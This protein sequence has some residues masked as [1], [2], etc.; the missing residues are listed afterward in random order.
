MKVWMRG[1]AAPSIASQAASMSPGTQRASEAMVGVR[2][3]LAMAETASKSPGELAANPAS[4]MST[5]SRSSCRAIS[6]FSSS[7]RPIPADCSPSRSVVSKISTLSLVAMVFLPCAVGLFV[8]LTP[9]SV[10]ERPLPKG[11]AVRHAE[12]CHDPT[13]PANYVVFLHC[14]HVDSRYNLDAVEDSFKQP[15]VVTSN[16]YR[17]A[18]GVLVYGA[19]NMRKLLLATLLVS[20]LRFQPSGH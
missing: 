1:R 14:V 16:L 10:S 20:R 15:V 8:S 6:I 3:S 12:P 17:S 7:V 4:M 19:V 5:P 9:W 18:D 13:S 2:T 11:A